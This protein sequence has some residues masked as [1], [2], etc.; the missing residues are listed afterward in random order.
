MGLIEKINL[1]HLRIFLVVYRTRSMTLAAK[2]LHLTQSGVSQQIKGL[3]D[4]LNIV[5]FD[6][7]GRK[8]IPTAQAEILYA[9]C[10]RKLDELDTTLARVASQGN[11]LTG[12]V[13]VGFPP[14][15]G[16]F[17][18]LPQIAR[19][20]RENPGVTFELKVGLLEEMEAGLD[21]GSLDLAFIDSLYK[22]PHI[23]LQQVYLESLH[24]CCHESLLE[25]YGTYE[26][27]ARFFR[28]LPYI[29]YTPG[30]PMFREW[31]QSNFSTTPHHLNIVASI[32]DSYAIMRLVAEGIG[33][34]LLPEVILKKLQKDHTGI[35]VFEAKANVSNPICL[36]S[37]ERRTLSVAAE[38]FFHWIKNAIV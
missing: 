21:D 7:L 17:I 5:L 26:F 19:F 10:S 24:M 8:I 22:A 2:E 13:R 38:G 18:V 16:Q 34:A 23:A 12:V 27:S 14:I 4:S 31:F 20:A 3:E 29:G 9:E 1:N 28:E 32:M 15:F 6:R 33:V 11:E 37:L 35:R 25:R 36:A 30:E